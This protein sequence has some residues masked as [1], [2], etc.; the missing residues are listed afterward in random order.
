MARQVQNI[1]ARLDLKQSFNLGS[2]YTRFAI[3]GAKQW[4]KESFLE[5]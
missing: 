1:V 4:I 5:I 3:S 2:S